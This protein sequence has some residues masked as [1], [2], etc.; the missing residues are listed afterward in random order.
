[1]RT[2]IR[3]SDFDGHRLIDSNRPILGLWARRFARSMSRCFP[4]APFT[5]PEA[6]TRIP[7]G[8]C[9]PA[10]GCRARRVAA[11]ELPQTCFFIH[12]YVYPYMYL[13]DSVHPWLNAAESE[14]HTC[15]ARVPSL[16]T[17]LI[18]C[19]VSGLR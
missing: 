9:S 19:I 11:T 7:S 13:S 3:T 18:S 15:L 2:E 17:R 5:Y 4:Q 16:A 8:L 14:L 10:S 12:I 1:M 6:L